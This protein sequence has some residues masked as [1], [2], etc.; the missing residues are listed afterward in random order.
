MDRLFLVFALTGLTMLLSPSSLW[1][2]ARTQL[3]AS[4][5][6]ELDTDP[7]R[8]CAAARVP[9]HTRIAHP[10]LQRAAKDNPDARTYRPRRTATP[11]AP[12]AEPRTKP[13]PDSLRYR[14]E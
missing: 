7:P 3:H 12:Q 11:A 14:S 2:Q 9:T 13:K 4:L 10:Y 5:T 6:A 1:G 8:T